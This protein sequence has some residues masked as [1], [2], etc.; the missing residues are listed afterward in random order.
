MFAV[1][2]L[3]LVIGAAV[4]VVTFASAAVALFVLCAVF[5]LVVLMGVLR[6]GLRSD[7]RDES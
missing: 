5:L 1:L 4:L 3:C 7:T 2:A 6:L